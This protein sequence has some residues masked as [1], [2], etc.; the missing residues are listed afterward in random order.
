MGV[1]ALNWRWLSPV[2]LQRSSDPLD[3]LL[4][5][6]SLSSCSLRFP[7]LVPVAP[8]VGWRAE[9]CCTSGCGGAEL[10]L[11][12][13]C[14]SAEVLRPSRPVAHLSLSLFLQSAGFPSSCQSLLEW[15]GEQS[16]AGQVG[17]EALN[18]RWLSPVALQR[19]S[20]PLDLLLISPSLSSCS[21][22]VSQ[23]RASRSSSGFAQVGVEALHWRWLSPV[24]LQRSSDPLDVLLIS[25]SLSLPA[26]CRFPKLVPV[27]PRV[28]WRAEFS[29]TSGCGGAQPA[30]AQSCSSA[31]VR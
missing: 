20:D 1:E 24:A 31:E 23:A 6:P 17:V 13:S 2:A 3:L 7:K 29:C 28:G 10:A 15:V 8:R 22:P 19:S 16:S 26:V 4:I 25:P 30:L 12:Q 11:A 27:A 9:F 18:W 21:L 5:S 14:S